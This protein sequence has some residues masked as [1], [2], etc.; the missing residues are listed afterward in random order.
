MKEE[1]DFNDAHPELRGGEI[2]LTNCRWDEYMQIGWLS[3]RSGLHA[4]SIYGKEVAGLLPV[5]VQ[6]KEY[7]K[8][9]KAILLNKRINKMNEKEK[10]KTRSN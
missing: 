10:V 2:F 4:Y 1:E 6:K 5:F 9:M 7:E 3:K 8:G